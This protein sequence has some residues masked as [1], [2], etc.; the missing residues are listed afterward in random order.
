M[1]RTNS[2]HPSMLSRSVSF[3]RWN[4]HPK[5]NREQLFVDAGNNVFI[6]FNRSKM[7]FGEAGSGRFIVSHRASFAASFNITPLNRDFIF[8]TDSLLVA[9]LKAESIAA[10]YDYKMQ[11]NKKVFS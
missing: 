4:Y 10:Q 2:V 1:L 3:M 7:N 11:K 8:T 5:F 9:V 6:Y